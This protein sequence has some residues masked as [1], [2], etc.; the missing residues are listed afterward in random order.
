MPNFDRLREVLTPSVEA[1]GYELWH[2]EWLTQHAATLL[3]VYIDAPGGIGVDDCETV[4]H[5]VSAV[6]DVEELVS[7][8]YTL[9]VSS[10]GT[11]RPLVTPAHFQR[12]VGQR[13]K[14]VLNAS[15]RGRR[16]FVGEL[17]DAGEAVVVVGVDGERYELPLT[18]VHSARLSPLE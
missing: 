11:D 14:I 12:F 2:L 15:L 13:A 16:R 7:S 4:S 1:L 17:L 3:R 9:E 8:Q 10:P 18:Q 5:Q 6:L